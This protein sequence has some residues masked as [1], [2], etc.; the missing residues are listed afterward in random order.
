MVTVPTL[1]LHSRNEAVVP[2][3]AGREMA[4]GIPEAYRP[5]AGTSLAGLCF[6]DPVIP[7]GHTRALRMGLA[8]ASEYAGQPFIRCDLGLRRLTAETEAD[9]AHAGF[10][11]H[12]HRLQH[13]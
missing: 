2:F 9:G 8:A 5:P 1:V 7:R 10:G 11:R 12:I 3:S 13:G 4:A 6:R